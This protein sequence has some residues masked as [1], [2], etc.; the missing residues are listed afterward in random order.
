[1][2][3]FDGA[4]NTVDISSTGT[5]SA[6]GGATATFTNG[7]LGSHSVT[8]TDTGS[9]TITAT[10]SA[11]G[12]GSGTETG[13]SNSFTVDPGPMDHFLVEAVGGGAIATQS[14][15]IAFNVQITAQD[16]NN[17]TVTPFD[18]AGNTV[19]ISSTG[20]LSAGG[21]AT[22]TFANGVLASHSV[23][24]TNTGSFT[25]TATDSAGGLGTGTETGVSNS[26]T[27]DPG[28][29]DHFLVEAVG[30]GAIGTQT[31]GTGINIQIT[32]QDAFN[33]T[34]T[35]FDGAGNTVEISSTG[36]LSAGSGATA[37]FTN[38]VLASHSVTITNTGSFT[39]TATDSAGGEGTGTESGVSNSFT[40]DPGALDHFLVEAAGGGSIGTQTAAVSFNI[41][42][43]AQDTHDN[44]VTLFNG[45]GNTVEIS[46]T[47]TLSA[48]SGTT[49]TFTNGVLGSHS[50]TITNSGSFTITATDS[51]GGLGGGTETGV[52]NTFTVNAG[53]L[54]HFLVEMAGGGAIPTQTAGTAFNIQVTAQDVNNN[55]VTAFDF[56][57]NTV[58]ISSTGTLSAGGGT[59][60]TFV[61]GVLASHSVTITNTGSFTITATDSAGGL[62]S[63]TETGVSNSFTVDPGTLDHFLVEAVGGGA[64]PTQAAAVAFSIQITA[65]DSSNNTVT[66]FDGVGN[67]AEISSTGTL[68]AGG[69]TTA[70]FVNGVLA[71]HSVTI[72][73][74]GSF[75][76]TATDSAGGL[77]S[78]AEIGVSNS[79][80]VDPGALDHF[81]VE[82]VGG[83]AIPAQTAGVAF[84]IQI[85]ARDAGNNTVTSFDFTNNTVEISSTGALSAGGGTTA[86]FVN[87]VL[88]SHSV[89]ISNT[90]SFT[91]TATDSAGG[92]G[93]G[94][95][96]GVSNSF[97][98]N[99]GGLNHFL[100]E[101]VGGG[102][103][104]TQAAGNAFNIQITAQDSI[105]NTVT[106]FDG[107]GNT[108]EIS[109][110]GTLSAGNGTTATFTNGVLASHSV[111][112]SDTGSFTITATDSAGGLGTGTE[113]GVS[114]SFTV[115][116]GALDHFLVEAFGGGAIGTQ[117]PGSPFNI[118]ITAQDSNNNTVTPFN[119]ATNT[120]EIS[121]TGTLS[122]GSGTTANFT[123]GVLV[124]HSVTIS[125]TGNF[126]ITATDSA[127]GFGTG[128]ETGVSN[129]F[130]VNAGA[131]DHFLVEAVGG[132][133]IGTQGAGVSFNI[134]ITAQ[135]TGN[136]TV[137]L[138]DGP[139]NTVEIS[140]TGT[141]SAGSGTTATFTNGVLASHSVTITD[142]GSFTITATDSAG[143]LGSGI[144][145]GVSN[146][147]TVDPGA[148]DHFLVEAVGGG[149]IGT[150]AA[151]SAFNIRITAQDTNN[152]TVTA[153]SGAGNT[154]EISSTGNLS[155]GSGTTATLTNG[156]LISHSVTIGNVGSFTITATD[157]AGGLGTGTET[158]VS[159]SFTVDPGAL[160]HFLVE[161]VGGGAIGTQV[162]AVSFDI[163]ITAQDINDN[164][165]TGFTGFGNTADISS[166]GVLS[167]GSGTTLPFTNGILP[168]H[169]VTFSSTGSFTITATDSPGGL[170]TGIE[171][172]GSNS[173][174]VNA[175]PLDHFL[176]E[177]V[178]GGAIGA[179]AAGI[180][181]DIQITA[182]DANNNTVTAFDFVG[183]T[184]EVSSTGTLSAGGG[185]TSAFVAGVLASHS[186]TISN[187]GS[188]TLTI[189]DSPT[190]LGTGAEIGV[191]NSFTVNS[192]PL[193][194]FVVEAVGGGSIGTQTAGNPFNIQ[195]TAQDSSNNT[196]IAFDGVGNTAEI[197]ST[198]TL[199]AG[200]GTTTTFNNG[201]LASHSV[202]ITNTG[203]FTI[204]ATDSAGGLGTGT[205]SGVSNS[206]TVDPGP[207]DH[208]LVEAVGG[209]AIPSQASGVGFN[210]QITAQDAN[211][212]TVTP[213]DG[214]TNTVEISSSGTLSA[215]SGTTA[216]F[217]N[218]VL[219]T[220][221]VTITNTGSFTITATDS[222][223]GLG[224]GTEIGASNSFTV[225][226]GPLDH[227]LVE[228]IGG[229]AIG[230][231]TAAV[232]FDIR[233]TAQDTNNNTVTN[234]DGAGNTV[235]ISSTGT[236]SAGSGI[237][238]NFTNG[239]LVAHNVTISN[240][241]NFTITATD[242]AGGLG[243]GTESGVSNS[244][245][246]DA[247][248]LDHFLVEAVGG[249]AI[250]T[251]VA[252]VSFDI[253]I[254]A[255]DAGNNT[256]LGFDGS[257][258]AVDI[259]STGTLSAGS[260]TTATFTNGILASHS[261]TISNTGSFTITATDS[262]GGLGTGAENGVTN[263]F[264]VDPGALDHFLVEAV[265][266]GAIGT[267]AAAVSFDI[268][269]AAQDANNNTVTPFDGVGNTVDISST[270]TL[271]AGSGTTATFT[272]GVLASHSVTISN[273]GS[274]TITATDSAG[275]IGSG[276]ENG[277]SNSFTVD[278][279]ALDHFLMEAVGGGAIGTQV[280]AVSF[281]IQITAQD[282]GNNTITAF[283]GAGNTVDISST[284]TL[285]AGSGA[286][287]TFT[288]GVLASHSVTIS[289]NGSFTITATD[290]VG[291]QGTGSETGVSNSFTVDAGALDHFLVEAVGG[292]AIG[293]QGA[294]VSFDIQITAQDAGNNTV[295]GF[296]GAGNTVEISSTGTLSAGNGT[297]ATFTNGVLASHS[298]TITN[299]GS[300]TIT[301][302][303][304]VG[305][306]GTGAE[307]GVTNS[308]T[309]D[310]GPLDHFLVEAV[311]G[312][313]IGTQSAAV[314]FDIQ[315]TA[316][317]SV[318]NTITAFDGAGNTAQ[319]SSTGTL[320]AGSGATATFTNG[321]LAS[322]SV[323]ISNTGSFTITATDGVGGLGTAT[324][325]GVSN[326]FTVD[327]GSLDHFLV[328]SVGGG[329]IGTQT[330]AVSFDV[331]ITAQDA[332]NN[333]VIAFDGA[334]NTV[335]I[336][337]TGTLS[338]GSGTTATFTSGV[339]ASH[340][341]TISNTGS[342]TITATDSVGGLGTGSEVGVSN[343]FTVNAGALDHFLVETVGGTP[344]GTQIAAVSFDIQITAQDAG[345]N[346]VTAFDGA[347]NTVD[348]S[349]T[350]TLSLGS[351]TTATFTNG[352]LASHSVTITNTGMFTITATDSAGGAGTGSETGVSNFFQVN[353]GSLDHFL[354]EAVGGGVIGTQTAG[355]AFNI[356]I[357]AQDSSN[358]TATSFDTCT[359]DITST[360]TLS[361]GSGATLG[362]SFGVLASHSVTIIDTGSFTITATDSS[363]CLG[364]GSER[365]DSN[366]FT[367]N[368]GPLDHFLVE[369][370]GGGAIG[371]QTA[372]LGFNI[373]IT[374]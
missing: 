107:A 234:F 311:G 67:T 151:D 282:A 66:L 25:I 149:A 77:G 249:G 211:N 360:G 317:D 133:A 305:G 323:T 129:A 61:G 310:P 130:T 260:G 166:T 159:N 183:N 141:L 194:H 122:A 52:S 325:T 63:G 59:S 372:T 140:S 102:A 121:S 116:P 127:G 88:T 118:R 276:T 330:V 29:V 20:T 68:S 136:N 303:D 169:S 114:N 9:F 195:V 294:G 126:T 5:L 321:V 213:F 261:V 156:V 43:T 35:A 177:A 353:A 32:A 218:G 357:T 161:A 286:T 137:T 155:T 271:S 6:G 162:A 45:A 202:T 238:A 152:N 138:F 89:T 333:T 324:E 73:N 87:G 184:A 364:S 150:Q 219:A 147:F 269:I 233:V 274:F 270:G 197:S 373:Q 267:Q 332:G 72:T 170:G 185:T 30:G 220:H 117:T 55:T 354:V 203:S 312:G 205:E 165:V 74:T 347:G 15:A 277:V 97:T 37:T 341:V 248:P 28:P 164:T 285:S 291:G 110:T 296:D 58:E 123:N 229:G 80:N 24:I 91:I 361:A 144:E 128:T 268:Q 226:P 90:G 309:V 85:T 371:T 200:A 337:S 11:G 289:N 208:F 103:I 198:G 247:G 108:V 221:S 96:T 175:G 232:A 105:N 115:D 94:T 13:V 314:S 264:T 51:A 262:V 300:F 134:Q 334:G 62:G 329:A 258:N 84:S 242:S 346:T 82:A 22:A 215:G 83:G 340:S 79:F 100:V 316:Q 292:G 167:A 362:F 65:Q 10:D 26:F 163:Q 355:S 109:S 263:S 188:F 342:F 265:G 186:V 48:G 47:G 44:T 176:V 212:N 275:G 93:T 259:S 172:G 192:G 139:G 8:I 39:I 187:T 41:Q 306:L 287:A 64:I 348:I 86:T 173:F 319:I 119:G 336:T 235:D 34:V 78:G 104:G 241:G 207:L 352:F 27:V 146:S 254:T 257:G 315:I 225:D 297:T 113:N 81:L 69:G 284:G 171:S 302:T 56:T 369:A 36:T 196:V 327:P 345:N 237:T 210:I 53:P 350:G 266:G 190:G 131:L 142:T 313:A 339:L 75:T 318:N 50:A 227:F 12:L 1:M 217:T 132:G 328:E 243:S 370:V 288:N 201:V 256:V 344:I 293:T 343:S 182:Q 222:A 240:A 31:A 326:S 272:N 33:N 295:T 168:T 359:V 2:T 174:V 4:G 148:L 230:N 23:T 60:A 304:S 120:V 158:G 38:G 278:P 299:T 349:S 18:G 255:Q 320:S 153:F 14:A 301:A 246:V 351:G 253:Q 101:A 92:L 7:V 179:Q 99:A 367:V 54:D 335:D 283:D 209:G 368:P 111:T 98:V 216:I 17:N 19:D 239:V 308:F 46:S 280:V 223:G 191:S 245:T 273:T 106:A 42:V 244:F 231:Q 125:N 154:V 95:E 124:S 290:S 338:A 228:A 206:F 157:S 204:T 145:T 180:A 279:G 143:G 214:A 193:D 363:G 322:H 281:D 3:A 331:Q 366:S 358:N 70:T 199:S 189:T 252:G 356:E 57:G 16:A 374:A 224:T 21:G 40:V 71:S 250:G 181:F 298:V 49:G 236:L 135:D 178:G 112:F 76:I 251:Q 365:G 160:D 307:I